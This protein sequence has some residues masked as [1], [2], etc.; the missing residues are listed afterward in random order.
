MRILNFLFLYFFLSLSFTTLLSFSTRA[1]VSIGIKAGPDF[2]RFVNAVQGG[3]G[4]GD[5][6]MLKS[7]TVTQYYGEVFVDIPLDSAKKMFFIRP[8]VEYIGAGGSMNP[9]GDYNNPNGFLP[10]TKYTLH[11]VD[12]PVEFLFS[13]RFDWGGPWIGLGLYGGTLVNGTIKTQ[14]SSSEPVMIGNNANDNFQRFDF[15]YTF[16][17][18]LATKVG[19]L[20]GI[21]YQH[22]FSRVVPDAKLQSQLPR[23]DT[24]NSVW[25]LHVGWVFKL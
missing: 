2:A 5:I 20:F 9:T 10:S 23:L 3:N 8:G 22:G 13:P 19:F 6:S 12:V 24:R 21:D 16:T 4:G 17:M 18:G 7:G 1:Q 25:G 15:G 14:G 11:Y